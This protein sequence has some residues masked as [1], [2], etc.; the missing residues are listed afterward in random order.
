MLCGLH[1][2]IALAPHVCHHILKDDERRVSRRD[3]NGIDRHVHTTGCCCCEGAAHEP[4]ALGAEHDQAAAPDAQTRDLI[5][6]LNERLN[7]EAYLQGRV[8]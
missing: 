6:P 1:K 4:A 5:I 8:M 7:K 3:D 2:L